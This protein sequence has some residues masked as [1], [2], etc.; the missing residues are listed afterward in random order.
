MPSM[1]FAA[2]ISGVTA[3]LRKR[4]VKRWMVGLLRSTPAISIVLTRPVST[5]PGHT[6]LTPMSWRRRSKRRTS[7][8]PR[9]PNFAALYGAC[10]GRPNIPAA[11]D[12]FTTW[13]PRPALIIAGTKDSSTWIGPIRLTSTTRRHWSCESLSTVPQTAMPA[14]FITM[15]TLPYA[16]CVRDHRQNLVV[17]NEHTRLDQLAIREERAQLRAQGVREG[18]R[19]VRCVGGAKDQLLARLPAGAA[20]PLAPSLDVFGIEAGRHAEP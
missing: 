9:R 18:A 11:E 15:S 13:P 8:I 2:A 3:L 4:A 19:G 17:T 5:A 12:T 14:M 6:R 1:I 16:E 20:G 7:E 10:H